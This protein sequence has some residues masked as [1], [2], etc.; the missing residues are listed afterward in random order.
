MSVDPKCNQQG[1]AT[2]FGWPSAA[3]VAEQMQAKYAAHRAEQRK[4]EEATA[5]AKEQQAKDASERAA[6]TRE[7]SQ[8]SLFWHDI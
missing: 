6:K 2:T 5:R 3:E 4:A 8:R 7:A 1:T